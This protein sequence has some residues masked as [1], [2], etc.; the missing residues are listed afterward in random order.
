MDDY[1][2][3]A[4]DP[5][6]G[7]VSVCPGGLV[8]VNLVHVSLKFTSPDF[9]RFADLIAKA[10]LNMEAKPP[11][12]KGAPRLQVVPSESD[13]DSPMEPEK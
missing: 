12:H 8:H 13:K 9:E 11:R 6:F 10:R 7:N 4:G 3:L 2:L 1:T 5:D